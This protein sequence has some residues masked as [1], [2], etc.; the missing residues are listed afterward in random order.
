MS[1][2]DYGTDRR[3]S[4]ELTTKIP[5]SVKLSNS[6]KKIFNLTKNNYFFRRADQLETLCRSG[7]VFFHVLRIYNLMCFSKWWFLAAG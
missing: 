4:P 7:Q 6:Q 1:Q 2:H 5:N 3:R